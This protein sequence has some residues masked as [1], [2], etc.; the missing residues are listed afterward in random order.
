MS[1]AKLFTA[2]YFPKTPFVNG[3]LKPKKTK[4]YHFELLPLQNK[5]QITQLIRDNMI[6][7]FR[8][9]KVNATSKVIDFI[10]SK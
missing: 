5:F 8:K 4:K 1:D 10:N 3:V 9:R 2:A 6:G 7:F